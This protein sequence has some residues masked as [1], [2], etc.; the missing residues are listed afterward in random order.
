MTP[1]IAK[2]YITHQECRVLVAWAETMHPFLTPN[3]V[4]KERLFAEV[5]TLPSVPPVYTEVRKRLQFQ[6]RLGDSAR[7]PEFGWFLGSIGDGGVVHPHR[8][9][10]PSGFRHLRCNLFIQCPDLGG[11]PV[12]EGKQFAIEEG[13][14][15][16]F[17]PSEQTH[18]SRAV[19]GSRRRM[20]CSFGYLVPPG[21]CLSP[22]SLCPSSAESIV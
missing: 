12:I 7:E 18:S 13:M 22:P 4:G 16:C 2:N 20:M 10:A 8:D 14:L 6:L 19:V 15:L 1:I 11:E 21:Y 17:Y 3:P 5:R 9:L